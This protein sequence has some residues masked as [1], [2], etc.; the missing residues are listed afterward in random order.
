MLVLFKAPWQLAFF[1]AQV[2]TYSK[3]LVDS[4]TKEPPNIKVIQN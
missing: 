2:A 1:W 3:V 4:H